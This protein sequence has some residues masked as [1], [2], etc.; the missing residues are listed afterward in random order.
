MKPLF[1]LLAAEGHSPPPLVDIDGT[2]FIQ[3]GIFVILLLVLNRLVFRPYLQ[4]RRERSENIEG[5]RTRAEEL[6]SDADDKIA[7]YE[8]KVREARKNAASLR[9]EKRNE[10]DTR[11]NEILAEARSKSDA[12]VETAR[13]SIE[14][15]AEAA[16]SALRERADELAKSIATKLL[17]REV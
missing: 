13:Q 4:V 17:G 3:F 14:K 10:G 11:A 15:S 2:V 7:R 16:R 9:A 1:V 5:A 8:E 6:D 12:K